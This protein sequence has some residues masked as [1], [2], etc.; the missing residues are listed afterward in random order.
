LT[1]VD[2][3][4]PQGIPTPGAEPGHEAT[5]VEARGLV[6][7]AGVLVAMVV[8]SELVLWLW[9]GDFRREEQEAK[10]LTPARSSV[11][12]EQFP[13]PRLQESPPIELVQLKEEESRR[14]ETYGWVD[15]KAGV[16]RIPVDRAMDILAKKGLPK[17][18]A[19]P[20]TPGAPP[21]TSIPPAGK[22]EEAGPEG[23]SPSSEKAPQPK[24]ESGQGGKP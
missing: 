6:V 15:R 19:P 18:A 4:I 21:N 1:D 3:A 5:G 8:V 23:S 20:P 14:I 9:M 22:R 17:V 11:K 12:V 24:P 16:A 13:Q 7:G 10:A 2:D